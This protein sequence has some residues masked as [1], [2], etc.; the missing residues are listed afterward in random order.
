MAE[1]Q[2][3]QQERAAREEIHRLAMQYLQYKGDVHAA[4]VQKSC[5]NQITMLLLDPERPLFAAQKRMIGAYL[6]DKKCQWMFFGTDVI[7]QEDLERFAVDQ[8]CSCIMEKTLKRWG[9]QE[10]DNFFEYHKLCLQ[11]HLQEIRRRRYAEVYGCT[12]NQLKTKSV[13][14][15]QKPMQSVETIFSDDEPSAASLK[16]RSD[17]SL[18]DNSGN[19]RRKANDILTSILEAIAGV[20]KHHVRKGAANY[21][22]LFATEFT[23]RTIRASHEQELTMEFRENAIMQNID[24]EFLDH[25]ESVPCRSTKEIA[26]TRLKK[27]A[28]FSIETVPENRNKE[29]RLPLEGFVYTTYLNVS[30]AAV[31][32]QKTKYEE[33]FRSLQQEACAE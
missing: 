33:L 3:S 11:Y 20:A 28:D 12:E 10:N 13:P 32:Q 4:A 15:G 14:A 7:R 16:A 18:Q 31:S 9:E 5:K 22:L 17:S 30:A 23:V 29:I 25:F 1:Y 2:I 6:Y 27:Y 21:P 26:V 8:I 19:Q 24:T